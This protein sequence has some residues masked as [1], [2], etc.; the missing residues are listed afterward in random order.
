MTRLVSDATDKTKF[1]LQEQLSKK[2]LETR[3]RMEGS[4]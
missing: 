3:F 4:H 2:S 1:D